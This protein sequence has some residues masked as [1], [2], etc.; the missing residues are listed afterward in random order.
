M[1]TDVLKLLKRLT[2]RENFIQALGIQPHVWYNTDLK[3]EKLQNF[4]RNIADL[5]LKILFTEM[6]VMDKDLPTDIAIRDRAIA[7]LYEDILS[8]IVEESTVIRVNTWEIGDKRTWISAH[9][10]KDES[11]SM[12][13]LS[14][15]CDMRRKLAWNG[16]ARAFD[17][18]TKPKH[19]SQRWTAWK[20]LRYQS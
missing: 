17:K 10:P 19:S 15:D 1:R 9:A 2:R 12:R 8:V 6:D 13:L 18:A 3:V 4:L 14:C 7:G 5:G 16:I 11:T 20:K